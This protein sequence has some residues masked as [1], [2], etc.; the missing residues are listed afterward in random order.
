MSFKKGYIPWNK[1]KS[2]KESHPNMGFQ[3]GNNFADNQRTKFNQFKKGEH[4]SIK[5]QFKKGYIPWNYIEDRTKVKNRDH[6]FTT[7][8]I[9][10][11]KSVFERDGYQCRISEEK[12]GK[13]VEAHHIYSWKDYVE[14]RYKINN[15]ITL[16]R[17]HHP[18]SRAE[19]KRL[20]PIFEELM[21]VSK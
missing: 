3:K 17:A 15:G 2:I 8:Y 12:C 14:L 4:S 5:T 1:G 6:H 10:W 7:E 13:Y 18:R 21:S 11:R 20:I 19:E 9:S 16:C